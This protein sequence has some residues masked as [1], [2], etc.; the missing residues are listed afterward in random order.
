MTISSKI[1]DTGKTI[2]DTSF[3]WDL[4]ADYGFKFGKEQ[5]VAEISRHVPSEYMPMFVEGSKA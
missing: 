3:I 1:N 4:V 5:D 2:A